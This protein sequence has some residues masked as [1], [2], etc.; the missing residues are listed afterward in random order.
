M[1]DQFNVN[2][3]GLNLRSSPVVEPNNI[4]TTLSRG[5]V[6][7]KL[8]V[9]ADDQWWEVSAVVSGQTFRGFV[10]HKFLLPLGGNLADIATSDKTLTFDELKQ[11][12]QLVIEIQKRLRNLGLYPGGPWIDGLLGS[13][14]S[15]TWKA[16]QQ[17][18]TVFSLSA[19]TASDAINPSLAQAL[20]G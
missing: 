2:A 5:Q 13:Q 18:S 3:T 16:L 14:N 15:R 17:F 7:T 4:V 12:K 6:V 1:A 11:T 19:P 10:A 8:A 9:A 20:I